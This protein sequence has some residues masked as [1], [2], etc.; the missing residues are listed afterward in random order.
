MSSEV[1]RRLVWQKFT[2]VTKTFTATIIRVASK[3][4]VAHRSEDPAPS[5]L[6]SFPCF[7]EIHK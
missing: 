6:L 2:D 3:K 1:L 7:T 5:V 4:R